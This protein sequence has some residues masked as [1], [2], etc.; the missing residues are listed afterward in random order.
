METRSPS[1]A[2][3]LILGEEALL[4]RLPILPSEYGRTPRKRSPKMSSLSG[5]FMRWSLMRG[6][7]TWAFVHMAFVYGICED[8]GLLPA[9]I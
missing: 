6:Q 9:F 1:N 2:E 3:V 8:V 4:N 5:R 7:A